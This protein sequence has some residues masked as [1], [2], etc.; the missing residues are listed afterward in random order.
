MEEK[1]LT[2]SQLAEMYNVTKASIYN[3]VKIKRLK[4]VFLNGVLRINSDEYKDYR[5]NRWNRT[6]SQVLCDG[7][8]IIDNAKGFYYPFQ[9]ASLLGIKKQ[10]IYHAM[11]KNRL[12]SHRIKNCYF[13]KLDEVMEFKKNYLDKKVA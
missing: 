12:K 11:R 3:A 6:K 7:S 5:Q 13:L 4:S 9:V 8:P 1:L 10:Q 2:F